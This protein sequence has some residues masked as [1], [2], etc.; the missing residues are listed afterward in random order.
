M[1]DGLSLPLDSY[2]HSTKLQSCLLPLALMLV[3]HMCT[4]AV[5]VMLC[6]TVDRYVDT[7]YMAFQSF[8]VACA[9]FIR[10]RILCRINNNETERRIRLSSLN[11]SKIKQTNQRHNGMWVAFLE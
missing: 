8:I 1:E 3:L 9:A 11:S 2:E 6:G 10:V 5:A 7:L 4:S